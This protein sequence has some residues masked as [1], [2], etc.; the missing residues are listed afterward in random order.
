MKKLKPTALKAI[1]RKLEAQRIKEG[2]SY[3]KLTKETGLHHSQVM[4]VIEG[5][6]NYT[7]SSLLLIAKT[8]NVSLHFKEVDKD[9]GI[10]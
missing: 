5:S 8:L 4:A 6:K 1:G 7:I 9:Q 10:E 2:Y 3:Y